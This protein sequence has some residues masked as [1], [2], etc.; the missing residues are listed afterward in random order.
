[1][2]YVRKA[3]GSKGALRPLQQL[4]HTPVQACA[5]A[6]VPSRIKVCNSHHLSQAR[7]FLRAQ[8]REPPVQSL[9]A[10]P[11]GWDCVNASEARLGQATVA[12]LQK[13]SRTFVTTVL[14]SFKIHTLCRSITLVP[15]SVLLQRGKAAGQV[16]PLNCLSTHA[17]PPSPFHA[18]A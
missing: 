1:M 8:R 4:Q 2:V 18:P 11:A 9:R 15:G 13:H 7:H 14:P 5:A 3:K 16:L 17:H 6:G 12:T 10:G